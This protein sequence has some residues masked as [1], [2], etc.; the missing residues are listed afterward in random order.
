M[1]SGEVSSAQQDLDV[2]TA[3]SATLAAEAT[4]YAD[5][6]KVRSDLA[7][8]QA[9]QALAMGGEVR[10]SFMLNNLALT[11]PQGSSLTGFKA[12]ISGASPNAAAPTASNTA[13]A[14]ST[15]SILG[16]SG[17]GSIS[18]DGEA[19]ENAKV[20][21]FL[22]A[23]TKNTGLLDPFATQTAK[24]QDQASTSKGVTFTAQATIGPKALSH[25]YDVKGN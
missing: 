4:K 14:G 6:P 12:A 7:S 8:A 25:R 21:A 17:I 9:Q 5:V 19:L 3:R 20:S 23:M 11:I 2:A 24:K 10:W 18:Y 1:A 22:E 16:Q 13:S 15:S